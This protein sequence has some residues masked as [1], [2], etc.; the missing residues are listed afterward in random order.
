M[1][2]S[3]DEVMELVAI[4]LGAATV[5]ESDCIVED[6]VA[7]SVDIVNIISALECRFDDRIDD[8]AIPEIHTVAD[9]VNLVTGSPGRR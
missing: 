6:L 8:A 3:P 2:V 9:L 7:E 4:Q 1:P 5:T